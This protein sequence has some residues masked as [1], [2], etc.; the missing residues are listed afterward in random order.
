MINGL[1]FL[2]SDIVLDIDAACY[3]GYR[4]HLFF[5]ELFILEPPHSLESMRLNISRWKFKGRQGQDLVKLFKL[6]LFS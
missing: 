1:L 5:T 6:N 3:N 4:Y 2:E